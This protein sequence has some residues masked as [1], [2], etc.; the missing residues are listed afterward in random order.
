MYRCVCG[1]RLYL[2]IYI[3]YTPTNLSGMPKAREML[4]VADQLT[5]R[6]LPRLHRHLMQQVCHI[7]FV[8]I[9]VWGCGLSLLNGFC[10]MC[11]YCFGVFNTRA[12]THRPAYNPPTTPQHANANNREWTTACSS[13]SGSSRSSPTASP[14]RCVRDSV[15]VWLHES[16]RMRRG[17][18]NRMHAYTCA[19]HTLNTN[20]LPLPP[21]IHTSTHMHR[22]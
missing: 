3:I 22:W 12:C 21:Y 11:V 5:R 6:H 9:C 17:N 18:I 13:R 4:F 10:T 7:V 16:E 19:P 2:Y 1:M 8:V 14:S 20:A 15:V